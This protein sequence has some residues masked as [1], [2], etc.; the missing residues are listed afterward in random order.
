MTEISRKQM[1]EKEWEELM[2]QARKEN[3][4]PRPNILICGYTGSGKT[5]LIK[6]ILG[7]IVDSKAIGTGEPK[8]QDFDCYESDL[9]RIYDSK[10][11][12]NGETEEQFVSVAREFIKSH[13]LN[14]PSKVDDHIHLVWYTIQGPGARVTDCDRKLIKEIFTPQN[15]IVCI[16]KAD[17][18]RE[19]QKQAMKQA[20]KDAGVREERIIFTSDE[21]GGC[22]G[23]KE[24]MECSFKMLPDACKDAFAEAQKVDI[25][26]RKKAV[27]Q[28]ATKAKGIIATAV[29][30]AIAIGA[31]PIPGS[32]APLLV[33]SQ[34]GM[35]ASLAAL[36]GIANEAFKVGMIPFLAKLAG[37]TLA[38]S[39]LKFIPGVGTMA[40]GAISATIAGTLTGAMGLYVKSY[41]EKCAIAKIEG[42][43]MP[44]IPWNPELFLQFYNQYKKEQK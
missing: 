34:T 29:T 28:K 10:G 21:E 41:F 42:K 8:T 2:E 39:L 24:L 18:M 1:T 25:E 32:D 20:V 7:D 43:P 9:V 26:L 16:T 12:E 36:Y 14:D 13:Q 22:I 3:G 44:E 23:N 5:S 37:T 11:M 27:Y 17:G 19:G 6:A 15:L 38:G 33:A 31:T 4:V 40:G 35:I 30:A